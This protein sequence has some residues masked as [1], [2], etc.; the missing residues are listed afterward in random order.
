VG[1]T[2]LSETAVYFRFSFLVFLF[3]LALAGVL[4]L[5]RRSTCLGVTRLHRISF[6][7]G[8]SCFI[9]LF[10]ATFLTQIPPSVRIRLYMV[11]GHSQYI[12]DFSN[13]TFL[14]IIE[15]IY[16]NV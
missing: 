5:H 12:K 7:Y 15:L 6:M 10:D 3:R 13:L 4:H 16:N 14:C 8:G 9:A 1:S 11:P 2:S